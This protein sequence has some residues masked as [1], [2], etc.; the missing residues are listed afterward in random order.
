MTLSP[1]LRRRSW[2]PAL[3]LLLGAC[4]QPPAT[5]PGP[6]SFP[7][8]PKAESITIAEA[9][10]PRGTPE[11]RVAVMPTP[12]VGTA[13]TPASPSG[14]A[15]RPPTEEPA[16]VSMAIEQTPLP[17]FIQILYGNVLKTPYSIDPAVNARTDIVTFKTS[18]P[19]TRSQMAE[20]AAA[21]LRSYQLSVQDLGG[22]VRI[23]PANAPGAAAAPTLRVGK[24]LPSTPEALRTAF[25][26][27]ELDVVKVAD[28]SATLR[29]ILGTRVNFQEDAARNALLLS[30]TQSDL[31]LA[32]DLIQVLD[33]P[34]LRGT[35][36]RRITPAN[37][38]ANEFSQRL[39]EVLT[40]QGYAVGTG[41]T[42]NTPILLIP[43]P[44][45]GS[46]MV[47]ANTETAMDM[48]LRWARELDRPIVAQ[49][50]NGLYTYAVKYADAQDLARTLGE[51]LGS[52]SPS[53]PVATGIQPSG[54]AG[55][56]S[57]PAVR[58]SGSNSRVVVNSATN[59]LIIRGTNADEYQ[60][61]QALLREL[62]RPVK[63]AMIEVTVAELRLGGSQSLGIEW[64]V[65][66]RAINSGQNIITAGTQG[67]LGIGSAGF[68]VSYGNAAGQLLAQ[69][70]TLA[71]NNQARILSNPKV[72]A[73]N[74]ETA[75][76][77]VGQE[78]P[79][80]TSQLSS[81][82]NGLFGNGTVQN[83]ISYRSTGVILRVRPVINSGNRLDLDV[84]QEVSSAAE[85]RTG[86]SA[87][88]T[89]ST[90]R[91]ETKLSL[92]DGSTVLLGGLISRTTSDADTGIPYLK[93]IP[94]VGALF[95]TQSESND[96]TELLVMITPYVIN[97]DFESEAI[98]EAIQKSFGDWAQTLK[99]SRVVPYPE[100]RPV[101][102][103]T[104]GTAAP[105]AATPAAA[106]APDLPLAPAAPDRS[107]PAAPAPGTVV[108][109]ATAPGGAGTPN[110]TSPGGVTMSRPAGA[111]TPVPAAP[112]APAKPDTPAQPPK[113][114]PPPVTKE[115]NDPK[116]RKEIE[117]LIRQQGGSRP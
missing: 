52:I 23:V 28:L 56:T 79:I 83:Q 97:D 6:L 78:V 44:A 104:P 100:A 64:N 31:Q 81:S 48:V 98:T 39:T 80:V 69:L 116:L 43:I 47:F 67:R 50:Q 93:D 49:T 86:V 37:L 53:A 89:I 55:V 114:T 72:M 42:T 111:P 68:L 92:R 87:S 8:S 40:A 60:Q 75:S 62:D 96:K 85:T 58:A 105:A 2:T 46:V 115:V 88:P 65:P 4:A 95:R 15:A 73:R 38:N 70:N 61:I 99:T 16:D 51:V 33:Q 19:V 7:R 13:A 110:T 20:Y 26:L 5:L 1:T 82:G 24:T 103:A 63:S 66:T 117:D 74:G 3:A 109:P 84:S 90:R 107:V 30:G 101:A 57:A 108:P 21:L 77:N 10:A 32:L 36:A 22:L 34:R 45:I 25:Q 17:M 91:I 59:T 102:P 94:G 112:V 54:T 11:T 14:N 35:V 27:V 71:S 18:R 76:I 9:A 113:P 29:Q 41:S 12:P 106:P